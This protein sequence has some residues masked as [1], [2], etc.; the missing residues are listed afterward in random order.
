LETKRANQN[1]P[2]CTCINNPIGKAAYAVL[3][4][5]GCCIPSAFDNEKDFAVITNALRINSLLCIGSLAWHDLL[6]LESFEA[7]FG[8]YLIK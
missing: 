2:F 3:I 4:L 1:T 8:G 7:K 5:A 6:A